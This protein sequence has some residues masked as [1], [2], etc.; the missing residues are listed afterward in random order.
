MNPPPF[1]SKK[2]TSG[3]SSNMRVGEERMSESSSAMHHAK[4][5]DHTGLGMSIAS[6]WA[7]E[8]KPATE[9]NSGAGMIEGK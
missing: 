3:I 9:L 8:G 7:G 1:V 5:R 4:K 2:A 6:R